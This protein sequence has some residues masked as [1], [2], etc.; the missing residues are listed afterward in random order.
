MNQHE[1][2]Q[3]NRDHDHLKRLREKRTLLMLKIHEAENEL[4]DLQDDLIAVVEEEAQ[5]KV[6]IA[7][8]Q[9]YQ[10]QAELH[11]IAHDSFTE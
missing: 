1:G 9:Y 4:K 8:T 6:I 11:H 7:M 2:Q 3:H 5:F 10:K